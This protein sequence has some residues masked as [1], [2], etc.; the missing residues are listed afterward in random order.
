MHVHGHAEKDNR[1]CQSR[2]PD[3]PWSRALIRLLDEGLLSLVLHN[4]LRISRAATSAL[5]RI[6]T[7]DKERASH[8]TSSPHALKTDI[9]NPSP[10]T[11][12]Y[13]YDELSPHPGQALLILVLPML[14]QVRPHTPRPKQEAS[15]LLGITLDRG[16]NQSRGRTSVVA[17]TVDGRS[18]LYK[19]KGAARPLGVTCLV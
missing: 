14:R 1:G 2:A 10:P 7:F 13:T 9:F 5:D 12:A 3:C 11:R 6:H 16:I 15:S 4:K 19:S 17:D 8:V 18:G